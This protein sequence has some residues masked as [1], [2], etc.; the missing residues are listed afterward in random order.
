[1]LDVLNAIVRNMEVILADP[2]PSLTSL[3]SEIALLKIVLAD[4]EP[5]QNPIATDDPETC[6]H[7]RTFDLPGQTMCQ[8]CG[9][10]ELPDGTWKT[11]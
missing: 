10:S 7:P 2:F 3:K 6:Q 8:T 4:L 1:M 5:T 9:A 11:L